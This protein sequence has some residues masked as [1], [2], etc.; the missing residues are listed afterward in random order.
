MWEAQL[1]S[2]VLCS[3]PACWLEPP[4][5]VLLVLCLLCATTGRRSEQRLGESKLPWI[6][7]VSLMWLLHCCSF[8]DTKASEDEEPTYDCPV[9]LED[10]PAYEANSFFKTW[11][12]NSLSHEHKAQCYTNV[13]VVFNI[14]WWPKAVD[15]KSTIVASHNKS[16]TPCLH[17]PCVWEMTASSFPW[18]VRCN[19]SMT[20]NLLPNDVSACYK[21]Y[22]QF[23]DMLNCHFTDMKQDLYI[24]CNTVTLWIFV[25]SLSP[26]ALLWKHRHRSGVAEKH[27]KGR[28][29]ASTYIH[30]IILY[31]CIYVHVHAHDNLCT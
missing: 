8:R 4:L 12:Y 18:K 29:Y 5:L 22:R 1:A 16:G 14:I 11:I 30:I 27:A 23:V 15:V 28:L 3:L 2:L 10:N 13:Q 31:Y 26:K 6:N 24:L 21:A 25:C 7:I 20:F 17:M 19:T 9:K